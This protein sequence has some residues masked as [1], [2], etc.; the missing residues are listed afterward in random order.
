MLLL[1]RITA[2][3]WSLSIH[4]FRASLQTL[5]KS[6]SQVSLRLVLPYALLSVVAY[7]ALVAFLRFRRRRSIFK[8]YPYKTRESLS[9]MTDHDAWAIQ[10]QVMQSE[11]PFM[12]MKSLQF[13][14][15]RVRL[16]NYIFE[17]R[18]GTV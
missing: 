16:P 8:K 3:G 18:P 10:K 11:F 7:L 5:T 9:Q 1:D 17:R 4:E 2:M 12:I 6:N 13:A 14:L 15:F